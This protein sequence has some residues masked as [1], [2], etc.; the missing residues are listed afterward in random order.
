[1]AIHIREA[2]M[3]DYDGLCKLI[4]QVDELHRDNRPEIFRKP[5]GLARDSNYILRLIEDEAVG[6]FVAEFNGRLVGFVIAAIHEA[7][8]IPIHVPRRYVVVDNLAV[9]TDA[10][11]MGIGQALMNAVYR[12]AADRGAATVELTVHEFNQSAMEF[13]QALGFET[14]SR[15]LSIRLK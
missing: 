5:N 3:Q 13:Y 1:M 8:A 6:L 12:W 15:K 2:G 10:R 7:G 4:E 11:R 14:V 9:D